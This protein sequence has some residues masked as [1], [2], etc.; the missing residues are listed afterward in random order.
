MKIRKVARYANHLTFLIRRIKNH[1]VPRDFK[2]RPPVHTKGACRVAELTSI[3]FLRQRIRLT[4][5]AKGDTKNEAESTAQKP[6]LFRRKKQQRYSTRLDLIP[7]E[8]LIPAMT[9]SSTS[10]NTFCA[11]N[12]PLFHQYL[13]LSKLTG[14]STC[15]LGL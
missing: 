10:L 9:V 11:R 8:S 7:S 12:R 2:V 13:S 15:H 1:I 6:P 4:Q 14:L 3:R 5:R